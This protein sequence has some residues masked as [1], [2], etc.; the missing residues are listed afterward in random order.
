[1]I[2][3]INFLSGLLNNDLDF[4]VLVFG[5]LKKIKYA[6]KKIVSVIMMNLRDILVSRM[7]FNTNTAK[8]MIMTPE[9]RPSINLSDWFFAFLKNNPEIISPGNIMYTKIRRKLIN[10]PVP[11]I[12]KV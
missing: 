4:V 9:H 2:E 7:R 5:F 6:I 1:M 10:I 3:I 11:P 12:Q 8:G